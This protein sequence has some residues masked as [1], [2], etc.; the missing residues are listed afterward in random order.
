VAEPKALKELRLA[1]THALRCQEAVARCCGTA[2]LAL[3]V[4][5]H[6]AEGITHL[7]AAEVEMTF[8]PD[9]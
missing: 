4:Q 9:K 6:L 1:I 8:G 3:S 5:H 7:G 2:A